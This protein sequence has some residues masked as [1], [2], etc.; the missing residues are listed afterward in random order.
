MQLAETIPLYLDFLRHQ[1]RA[2]PHT[3]RA[4]QSDLEHWIDFLKTSQGVT[5]PE[6]AKAL[7]SCLRNY[8]ASLYASHERSSLSRKLAS[9]RSWLHFCRRQLHLPLPAAHW[10]PN[11]RPPQKLP[12]FLNREDLRLLVES[13]PLNTTLGRRDRALLELLYG[14][15]LRVS[16]A[17]SLNQGSFRLQE[18]W[19]RVLGK[20]R[21]ER[22]I[23]LT[24]ISCQRLQESWEDAPIE[25]RGPQA[26]AFLNKEGGRLSSRSVGRI[27]LKYLLLT[28]LGRSLSAHGLRHSFATHLLGAGADL[29]TIQEL[30]GHA[31]LSTTQRYTH[32]DVEQLQRDYGLSHP[33]NRSWPDTA[34]A[35]ICNNVNA[36]KPEATAQVSVP[37]ASSSARSPRSKPPIQK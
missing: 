31:F 3:Q 4:Y 6:Q 37:S 22:E 23:P 20:G 16:E 25:Q 7:P 28:G 18:G 27:V 21:K 33:L 9:I 5:S 15:G 34:V 26:P 2:S 14:S 1:Q 19:V 32:V 30:L 24:P 29:R 12:A 11:L 17:V 35:S 13:P 36:A 8:L 10:V